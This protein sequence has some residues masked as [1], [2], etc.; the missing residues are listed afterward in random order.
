M[1][2]WITSPG[3]QDR[4]VR[5]DEAAAADLITEAFIERARLVDAD[6]VNQELS[7][8]KAALTW[9]H[10]EGWLLTNPSPGIERRPAPSDRTRALAREQIADLALDDKR[11]K[12]IFRGGAGNWVHWQSGTAQ[13]LP[14]LIKGRT[15]GPVCLTER[16]VPARTPP[17]DVCRTTGRARL[18][19][20]PAAELSKFR[21]RSLANPGV[22]G[23]AEL[24]LLGG[25][26]LHQLRHSVLTHE[27][28]DGTNNPPC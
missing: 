22:T 24:E 2:S 3:D 4:G 11:G 28:E 9:W 20:R 23:P 12:V 25:W 5:L 19:Y 26:T 8:F 10:R 7:V 13:L 15:R 27:A 6:T 1:L 14:R 17:L 21:T 16:K 18:S